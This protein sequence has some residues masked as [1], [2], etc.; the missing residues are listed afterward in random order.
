[1]ETMCFPSKWKDIFAI[2]TMFYDESVLLSDI[3]DSALKV[4]DAADLAYSEERS[5][6]TGNSTV[7]GIDK[8]NNNTQNDTVSSR[9]RE[10]LEE[11]HLV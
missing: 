6:R 11:T 2:P 4:L 3:A 5:N 9:V 10:K 8:T 7:D 1:M